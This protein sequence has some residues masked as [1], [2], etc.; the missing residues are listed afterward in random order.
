MR[1]G[2]REGAGRKKGEADKVTRAL[3]ESAA[4]AATEGVTPL[5][6]RLSVARHL[7]R[8]ATDVRG[9]IIDMDK[10]KEAAEFAEPAL[11]YTSPRL[12]AIQG[13]GPDGALRIEVVQI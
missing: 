1:G 7:W 2:R 4:K 9:V 10:A 5:E 3:R 6:M 12:N 13:N 8:E 11:A